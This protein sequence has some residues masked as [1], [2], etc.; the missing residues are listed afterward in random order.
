MI[1][2]SP[3]LVGAGVDNIMKADRTNNHAYNKT[4][5]PLAHKR[6]EDVIREIEAPPPAPP[7]AGDKAAENGIRANML[8]KV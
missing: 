3:P 1:L 5:R 7:L 6:I 8:I 4:L 2:F